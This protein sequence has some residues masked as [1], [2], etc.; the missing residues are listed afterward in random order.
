MIARPTFANGAKV[1]LYDRGTGR[2]RDSSLAEVGRVIAP[3]DAA[4]FR[5]LA[6]KASIRDAFMDHLAKQPGVRGGTL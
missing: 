4:N 1:G 5:P 2:I 3:G 6:G